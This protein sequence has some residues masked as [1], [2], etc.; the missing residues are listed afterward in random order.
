MR[1]DSKRERR[2]R[3]S[4]ATTNLVLSVRRA[5]SLGSLHWAVNGAVP[6]VAKATSEH[7]A[8][9]PQEHVPAVFG[10]LN[11]TV[12]SHALRFV[13]LTGPRAMEACA[14]K[15]SEFD[16]ANRVWTVPGERMKKKKPHR[17]PLT[18]AMVEVLNAVGSLRDGYVFPNTDSKDGHIS[19]KALSRLLEA[20]KAKVCPGAEGTPHGFRSCLT[21]WLDDQQKTI[22]I[23]LSQ[24]WRIGTSPS[25][26]S[27]NSAS[28]RGGAPGLVLTPQSTQQ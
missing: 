9:L 4:G 28:S 11:S 15:W 1:S 16:F 7:H 8:A 21:S 10:A 18:D 20:T 13:M 17:V 26:L 19:N 5:A 2:N 14:A 6:T 3:E 24:V 23:S 25:R 12:V 27:R 22:Y